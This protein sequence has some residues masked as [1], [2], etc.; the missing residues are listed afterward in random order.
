MRLPVS[1]PSTE[2]VSLGS[3]EQIPLALTGDLVEPGLDHL[4]RSFPS[5]ASAEEV[6]A[7]FRVST[8][9][10]RCRE[11]VAGSDYFMRATRTHERSD[12]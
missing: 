4:F 1:S 6:G 12:A 8:T 9:C 3:G 7:A 10:A 11:H 5:L 2:P